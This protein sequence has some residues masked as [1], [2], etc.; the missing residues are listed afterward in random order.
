MFSSALFLIFS[1]IS[2]L[3]AW[4]MLS[5]FDARQSLEKE[6]TKLVLKIECDEPLLGGCDL[7]PKVYISTQQNMAKSKGC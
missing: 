1:A 4:I 6:L 2:L 5:A 3:V 7:C